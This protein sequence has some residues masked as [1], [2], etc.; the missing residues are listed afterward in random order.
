MSAITGLIEGLALVLVLV[1]LYLHFWGIKVLK[2]Y[3][4]A[5]KKFETIS[6]ELDILVQLYKPDLEK[7]RSKIDANLELP[8]SEH[9]FHALFN[10][11]VTLGASDMGKEGQ[12]K[13]NMAITGFQKIGRAIGK[14]LKK[15]IPAIEQFSGLAGGG[16]AGGGSDGMGGL[17]EIAGEMFG[18]KIPPGAGKLLS[19][20]GGGGSQETKK[21]SPQTGFV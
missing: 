15:E 11:M 19:G 13:Q 7:W 12:A 4:V 6:E 1:S 18:I 17:I 9:L 2:K 14:G 16:S 5:G 10:T 8:I 3:D 21:E 20:L